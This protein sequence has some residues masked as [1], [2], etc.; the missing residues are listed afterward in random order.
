MSGF[1]NFL[2]NNLFLI[3]LIIIAYYVFHEYKDLK[4]KTKAIYDIFDKVLNKYLEKKVNETKDLANKI[5][6][7]HST[8]EVAKTEVNRLMYQIEKFDNGTIND[9]VATSNSLNKFKLNTKIDLE[10]YPYLKELENIG[11][12]TEEDMNS[13]ENGIAIARREYNARAFRYNEKAN[14]VPIQYLLKFLKLNS[15]F[16]IF[17]APKYEKYSDLYEVFEE[18][19]PE[20]NFLSSLNYNNEV[21]KAE[22]EVIENKETIKQVE[23]EMEYSDIILKPS[24]K[25]EQTIL[26]SEVT[27]NSLEL[28]KEAKESEQDTAIEEDKPKEKKN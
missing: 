8:D 5:L 3:I 23:P 18:K 4:A 17:D 11:T 25:I 9:K 6:N 22:A 1:A 12:F 19:E 28:P 10:K 16:I 24:T 15:Q 13:L 21:E 20:I 2:F 14:G 26:A 27:D 7:E